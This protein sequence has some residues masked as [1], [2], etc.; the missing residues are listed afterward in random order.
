MVQTAVN[1]VLDHPARCPASKVISKEW[2][3]FPDGGNIAPSL[4]KGSIYIDALKEAKRIG[5]AGAD[6]DGPAIELP[7]EEPVGKEAIGAAGIGLKSSN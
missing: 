3:G 7:A 1:Y 6:G 5:R 2:N 4:T